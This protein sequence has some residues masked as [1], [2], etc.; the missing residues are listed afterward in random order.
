MSEFYKAAVLSPASAM[1]DLGA[2]A[3]RSYAK[4]VSALS[5]TSQQLPHPRMFAVCLRS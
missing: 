5:A 3:V 1:H 2:G 4:S